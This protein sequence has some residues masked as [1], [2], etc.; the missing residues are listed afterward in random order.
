VAREHHARV[1][2]VFFN[3]LERPSDERSAFLDQACG[4]DQQVREEVETL[5]KH[6]LSETILAVFDNR[7]SDAGVQSASVI[8][9]TTSPHL[10]EETRVLLRGRLQAVVLI[11]CIGMALTILPQ[12]F[13]PNAVGVGVR[14]VSFFLLLVCFGVLWSRVTL[15]MF[16]LRL[17]ELAV[18]INMGILGVVIDIRLMLHE[19]AMRDIGD[20][21]EANA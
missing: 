18:L 12:V 2:Q 15:N 4:G 5:L 1:K 21:V 16:Q 19:A 10:A 14:V 3:V 8:G 17:I 11:L 20:L 13:R 7:K 6:H 9:A